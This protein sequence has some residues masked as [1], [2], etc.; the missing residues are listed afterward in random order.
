M[1]ALA[2]LTA[3]YVTGAE[4]GIK[5]MQKDA[6]DEFCNLIK[7]DAIEFNKLGLEIQK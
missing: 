5:E 7:L 4:F 3:M 6:A 1:L 2:A